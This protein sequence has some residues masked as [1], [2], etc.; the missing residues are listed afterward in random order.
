MEL[1]SALLLDALP[2]WGARR[3]YGHVIWVRHRSRSNPIRVPRPPGMIQPDGLNSWRPH[4][5]I[6]TVL[7]G[8]GA[9]AACSRAG[10]EVEGLTEADLNR[11]LRSFSRT[12]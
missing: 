11:V 6:A 12:G 5:S 1:D 3:R 4:P 8:R 10:S 7:E 9:A 2:E